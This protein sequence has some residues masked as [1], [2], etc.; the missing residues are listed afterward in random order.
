MLFPVKETGHDSKLTLRGR[1]RSNTYKKFLMHPAARTEPL[2]AT[3]IDNFSPQ[4]TQDARTRGI[5][6]V[7]SEK[8]HKI[9]MPRPPWLMFPNPRH[10][11]YREPKPIDNVYLEDM[12]L[13]ELEVLPG[14]VPAAPV[15]LLS[16]DPLA[17]EVLSEPDAPVLPLDPEDP[18]VPVLPLAPDEPEVPVLPLDPE[19]PEVPVL[20]LAPDEPEVPVLPLAPDE[21]LAGVSVLPEVPLLPDFSF[22]V[23]LDPA[24]PL[25]P[26]DPLVVESAAPPA[27]DAPPVPDAPLVVPEASLR[28][29]GLAICFFAFDLVALR[30]DVASVPLL[31]PEPEELAPL[32]DCSRAI[33]AASASTAAARAGSVLSRT[34]REGD[35]AALMPAID[36][37]E[38]N[39]ASDNFF[40]YCSI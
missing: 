32:E 38:I 19:D 39:N 10:I 14:L 28:F 23:A 3:W 21:P 13:P 6:T 11:D 9:R 18:E 34:S 27:L 22:G 29:F 2:F 16:A 4:E 24:A 37:K 26:D 31:A 30:S 35:C 12:P 20:P 1:V 33:R 17:P 15:V 25:A 5:R 36:I 7:P 8:G 40:I